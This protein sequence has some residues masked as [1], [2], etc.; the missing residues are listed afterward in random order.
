MQLIDISKIS[1]KK[2]DK[3]NKIFT[4]LKQNYEQM[5]IISHNEEI[6][7][8]LSENY[9]GKNIIIEN[10]NNYSILK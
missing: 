10:N 3:L 9:E 1:I 8:I 6:K 4:L 5:L 7:N 2:Y